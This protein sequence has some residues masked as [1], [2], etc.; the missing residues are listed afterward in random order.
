VDSILIYAQA[1]AEG[2]S[3]SIAEGGKLVVAGEPKLYKK[4]IPLIKASKESIIE[5]ILL[6]NER[7]FSEVPKTRFLIDLMNLGISQKHAFAIENRVRR[8]KLDF[9]DRKLCYECSNLKGAPGRWKCDNP[10]AADIISDSRDNALGD[11]LIMLHR[12]SG[13]RGN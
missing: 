11:L 5:Y 1:R 9:D 4:W 2:L 10:I 13:F 6:F 7:S 12:C 3:I 8:K